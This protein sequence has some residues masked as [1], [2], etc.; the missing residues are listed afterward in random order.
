MKSINFYNIWLLFCAF[1]RNCLDLCP[2]ISIFAVIS[3]MCLINGFQCFP[4]HIVDVLEKEN[5]HIAAETLSWFQLNQIFGYPQ[6]ENIKGFVFYEEL[7]YK[8]NQTFFKCFHWCFRSLDRIASNTNSL[9]SVPKMIQ[10]I[11]HIHT[12]IHTES[13]W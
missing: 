5:K 13:Q 6:N 1:C 4:S 2:F 11:N 9:T 3:H 7:C 12:H 8:W 10:Q